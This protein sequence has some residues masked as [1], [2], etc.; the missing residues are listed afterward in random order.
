MLMI[1]SCSSAAP[2]VARVPLSGMDVGDSLPVD[3]TGTIARRPVKSTLSASRSIMSS[4]Y[5]L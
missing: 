3:S 4:M 2:G 1:A 5:V